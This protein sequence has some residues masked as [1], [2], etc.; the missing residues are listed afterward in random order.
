M[1]TITWIMIIYGI[2]LFIVFFQLVS[3][4]S[5]TSNP[6]VNFTSCIWGVYTTTKTDKIVDMIDDKVNELLK[7]KRASKDNQ[8]V[9]KAYKHSIEKLL[10]LKQKLKEVAK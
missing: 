8:G 5:C 2:F 6:T 10:E 4:D 9:C 1:R 7:M 3:F